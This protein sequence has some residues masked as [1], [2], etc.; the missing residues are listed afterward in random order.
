MAHFQRLFSGMV[1]FAAVPSHPPPG[2]PA[3][4]R[5]YKRLCSLPTAPCLIGACRA[6]RLRV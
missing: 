5:Y 1:A 3:K 2:I 6:V 4:S